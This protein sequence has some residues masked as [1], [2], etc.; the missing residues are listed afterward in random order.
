VG[1]STTPLDTSPPAISSNDPSLVISACQAVP[2]RGLDI[3]R[4]HAGDPATSSWTLYLPWNSDAKSATIR[5]RWG[6]Q[7]KTYQS[8]GPRFAIPWY[9]IFGPSWSRDD[10]GLVQAM[11]DVH[12]AERDVQAL[13]YAFIV[14]MQPGYDPIPTD[15]RS[16]ISWTECKIEYEASGRSRVLCST[17][18]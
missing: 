5:V 3:C 14:V 17:L 2:S 12:Y 16:V 6:D 11:V 10:A 13:G 18:P 8:D 4:V 1:C 7:V 15:S 9:D